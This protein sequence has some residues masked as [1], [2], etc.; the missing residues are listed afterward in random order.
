MWIGDVGQNVWEEIDTTSRGVGGR[1][2]G[3]PCREGTHAYSGTCRAGSLTA[4]LVEQSH[5]DGS[6]AVMGGYVYRGRLSPALS[7]LYVFTDYCSGKFWGVGRLST[8][9]WVRSQLASYNGSITAFGESASGELYAV[10]G[11]SGAL[12]LV[13]G[14]AA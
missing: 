5:S 3:W 12:L 13:R 9:R 7:G 8:G 2:F 4:P 1:N 10:D 14:R 6:C 11:N